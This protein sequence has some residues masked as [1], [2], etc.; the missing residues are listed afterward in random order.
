MKSAKQPRLLKQDSEIVAMLL[1][2]GTALEQPTQDICE[3]MNPHNHKWYQE[4]LKRHP[5]EC[6]AANSLEPTKQPRRWV[7]EWLFSWLNRPRRLLIRWEKLSAPYEA[8]LKLACA[9]ICFHQ[10]AR[11]SVFG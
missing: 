5:P 4:A 2:M 11:L 9:L 7:V 10:S 1:P 3:S 8:F 6:E